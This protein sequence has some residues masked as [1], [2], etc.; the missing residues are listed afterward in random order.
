MQKLLKFIV[1]FV[2]DWWQENLLMLCY[3]FLF[4]HMFS[5][6]FLSEFC[7]GTSEKNLVFHVGTYHKLHMQIAVPEEKKNL[8]IYAD[9][10]EL[11][12]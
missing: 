5:L 9:N 10:C 3:F 4:V 1:S 12:E 7:R 2:F 11:V 6:Y 8:K